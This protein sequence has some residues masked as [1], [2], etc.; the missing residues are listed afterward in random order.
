M[1]DDTTRN[2]PQDRLRINVHERYE[3]DYWSKE[4]GIS[5]D[6]LKRAVSKAGVMTSDVRNYLRK[7]S[8]GRDAK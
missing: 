6:E 4:L 7:N 3:L 5:R 1:A 8:H 2:T